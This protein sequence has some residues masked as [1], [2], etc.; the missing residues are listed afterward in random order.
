[1]TVCE[2]NAQAPATGAPKKRA[3]KLQPKHKQRAKQKQHAD[4]MRAY[5]AALPPPRLG[6]N[7]FTEFCCRFLEADPENEK[8]LLRLEASRF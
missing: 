2:E 3:Y 7:A 4:A 8:R 6:S 5:R 1:M